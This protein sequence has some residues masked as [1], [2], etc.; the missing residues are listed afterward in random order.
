MKIG[1]VTFYNAHNYGA[2]WQAFALKKYLENTGNDIEIIQYNNSNISAMYPEELHLRLGKK[3]Y[4]FP[5]LWKKSIEEYKRVKYS[6][7]EWKVQ[8]QRFED[9]IKAYLCDNSTKQ[10]EKQV[11]D[12]ELIFLEVI[13]FGKKG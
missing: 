4:I 2:V 9:F 3:N 7:E 6:K 13:R 11:Y 1:I 5:S 12:K 10:W 8:Y